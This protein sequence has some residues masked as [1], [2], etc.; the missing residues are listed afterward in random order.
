MGRRGAN[1]FVRAKI[2]RDARVIVILVPCKLEDVVD[3][4]GSHSIRSGKVVGGVEVGKVGVSIEESS[5]TFVT[6]VGGR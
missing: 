6:W 3:V 2:I 4:G 5:D 1:I